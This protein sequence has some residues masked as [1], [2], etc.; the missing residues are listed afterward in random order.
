MPTNCLSCGTPASRNKPAVQCC[1]C[2]NEVHQ[3]CLGIPPDTLKTSGSNGR[4]RWMCDDCCTRNSEFP[5]SCNFDAK[6]DKIMSDLAAITKQQAGFIESLNFFGGKIDDV[7]SKMK[8]FESMNS[9]LQ[10]HDAELKNL[11]DGN[12]E[13]RREMNGLQQQLKSKNLDII[14][15][16]EKKNE[17]ILTIVENIASK[18]GISDVRNFIEGCYRIH[19]MPKN[20]AR[21]RPIVIDFKS[22]SYR[23]AF[24]RAYK[25]NKEK[26]RT[27][28]IGFDGTEK[29]IYVNESL[30]PYYRKLFNTT[31]QFC[32][33]NSY[34]YCWIQDGRLLV[35]KDDSSKISH[36]ASEDDVDRLPRSNLDRLPED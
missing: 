14:G 22:K 35:R 33:E 26:I 30:S 32:R 36:I 10:K 15:V 3:A 27:S 16:P 21:S 4:M 20:D 23:D 12:A 7:E 31:R 29:T 2:V 18:L 13:L 24:L 28:D 17:N 6:L 1:S 34:K 11:R 9:R 19:F 5:R 25:G 8:V